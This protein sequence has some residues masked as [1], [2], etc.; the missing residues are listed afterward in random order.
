M[1]IVRV[2]AANVVQAAEIHSRAW[3]ESHR[4]FCEPDFVAQHTPER[5]RAYFLQKMDAG[6]AVYMLIDGRPAAVV[7][8]AGSVIEDLYVLPEEQ[9]RGLGTTL[10]RFA[11][12]KCA[13]TPRLWILE[14]NTR[15]A[16]LYRR[17]GFSETGRRNSIAEGLD[18]IEFSQSD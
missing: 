7:S 9:N 17:L 14:N 5:Q 18:E 16:R 13:G 1:K 3:Q 11:C 8:V 6:S 4:A 2:D 10:L 12:E 15:A